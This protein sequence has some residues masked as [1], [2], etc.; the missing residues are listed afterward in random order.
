MPRLSGFI[1]ELENKIER[2]FG[3]WY[4]RS[5]AK[6]PMYIPLA[7]MA[8]YLYGLFLNSLRLGIASTFR[9]GAEPPVASIWV[10]DQIK[11]WLALF[12]PFGLGTTAVIALLI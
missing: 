1:E 3:R 9:T 10:F 4:E 6:L 5:R 8:L 2:R 12:T 7:L 11:N